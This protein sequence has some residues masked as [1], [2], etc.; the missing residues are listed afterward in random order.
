M[1]YYFRSQILEKFK[2][3]NIGRHLLSLLLSEDNY[4]NFGSMFGDRDASFL[5]VFNGD[6]F[7]DIFPDHKPS[8][9]I[10]YNLYSFGQKWRGYIIRKL[11]PHILMLYHQLGDLMLQSNKFSTLKCHYLMKDGKLFID[12]IRLNT[13]ELYS[14]IWY[15]F[16]KEDAARKI[17]NVLPP[18]SGRTYQYTEDVFFFIDGFNNDLEEVNLGW[19]I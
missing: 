11:T 8:T 6:N 17:L 18:L 13:N 14:N 5:R 12:G 2:E 15:D 10:E 19:T 3:H 1:H 4:V 7:Y 16:I 9:L